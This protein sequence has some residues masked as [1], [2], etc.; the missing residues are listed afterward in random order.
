MCYQYLHFSKSCKYFLR[1]CSVIWYMSVAVRRSPSL[2][3]VQVWATRGRQSLR[4]ASIQSSSIQSVSERSGKVSPPQLLTSLKAAQSEGNCPYIYLQV[5]NVLI[6]LILFWLERTGLD[7]PA[8]A[9][10]QW[11]HVLLMIIMSRVL[12]KNSSNSSSAVGR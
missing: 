7:M 10:A 4:I 8:Q 9:K 6:R 12:W 1:H 11:I 5:W 3:S 2:L